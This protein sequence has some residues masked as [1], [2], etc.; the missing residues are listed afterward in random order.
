VRRGGHL[1]AVR[2]AAGWHERR[3]H[4]ADLRSECQ[5][6]AERLSEARRGATRA[7]DPAGMHE[8]L[9]ADSFREER[10]GVH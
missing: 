5:A 7:Q 2:E 6:A 1:I 4:L 9:R 8:T 10:L 3:N